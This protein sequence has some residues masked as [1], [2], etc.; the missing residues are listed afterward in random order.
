MKAA[1]FDRFGVPEEVL[2][3]GEAATPEPGRGEVRVRMVASPVN[4]SDLLVVRGEYGKLPRLP[5]TPGFEG[6]GV[7][8]KSGGG[9]LALVR[10]LRP[11][12]RVAVIA[13]G[14]GAWA[15]FAVVSARY[16]IPLPDDIPDEQAAAFFVN[17]ASALAMTRHV[18]AVPPGEWLL[19]TAAGSALGRMVIRLGKHFGFRTINVVRRREQAEELRAAGADAVIC[20]AD[21][22]IPD[23]ARALTDGRGVRYAIDAVGGETGSAVVEALAPGG[24][25]L[26]YGTLSGEPMAIDPRLLMVGGKSVEGFWLSEWARAQR[27]LK[28]L[29]LFGAIR[30]LMRAGVLTSEVGATFPLD[31]IQKAVAQAAQP[32]RLGKVLLRLR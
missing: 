14:G 30:D 23:R 26:V 28:M 21:E 11:G 13:G 8:D 22:S 16:L 2:H 20:T 5:A 17:P 31:E 4:P 32:G 3:V 1:I 9:L 18:L 7:V 6:V 10:G 29:R 27:P 24:R 25:L 19:Q 12:R 15:E